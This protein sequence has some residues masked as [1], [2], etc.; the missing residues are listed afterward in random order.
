MTEPFGMTAVLAA[1][2]CLI[3]PGTE[4]KFL[5]V[6]TNDVSK[7]EAWTDDP[8]PEPLGTDYKDKALVPKY[9]KTV[10]RYW[11]YCPP[12]RSK[13][14]R[15]DQTTLKPIVRSSSVRPPNSLEIFEELLQVAKGRQPS[16]GARSLGRAAPLTSNLL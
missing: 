12:S 16:A 9:M 10:N 5:L 1:A 2:F 7:N 14:I 15:M 8:T 3:L 13:C 6:K 4:Q 11:Q